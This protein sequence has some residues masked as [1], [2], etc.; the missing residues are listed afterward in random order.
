MVATGSKATF[1]VRYDIF[2]G[3]SSISNVLSFVWDH[4]VA[5]F[6]RK[7]GFPKKTPQPM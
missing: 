5:S 4:F 7:Y 2:N 6:S 1:P 3:S